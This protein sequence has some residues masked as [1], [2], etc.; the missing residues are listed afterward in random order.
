MSLK[1]VH[2]SI[3]NEYDDG[4]FFYGMERKISH[5]LIQ[6]GHFVYDFS[7]RDWERN[8]RFLGIKNSGLKKMNNKLIQ[9]CKNLKADILLLG[10]AEKIDRQTL[11]TIKQKLPNLKIAQWYVDHLKEN[12]NFFDNLHEVDTFF[13]ANALPL[14]ELSLKYKD[15]KFS[16]FPNISDGAFDRHL[17]MPK[18][19]DVIYIARDY[20]ED[21]RYKFATLLDEFCKN[22]GINHKIYASLGN[23]A[24]FGS[25]FHEAV[26]SAKIAINFN[27][28]DELES[29]NAKKL[30]GASDRM[31]QFMGCGV[32]TF[33]PRID[34]FEKLYEDKKE[35]V[36]FDSPDDCFD[37]IKE[38]LKYDKFK[39]I[40]KNGQEKTLKT[41]NAKRV[42][43]FMIEA[44]Q[45]ENFS[46]YY[47]WRE[48]IYKN[49]EQI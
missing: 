14:K 6:N 38:Y 18:T 3:F 24:V 30:L 10:K 19:T 39:D 49:G 45:N 21:V 25:E 15:A 47:E 35:I 20:K 22:N 4:N 9:I 40:A 36:Y 37:K 8:L 16:F 5:G 44:L 28:D 2:C 34:G 42:T 12:Q 23:K 31:A 32:C 26:N 1:I 41:A 33:S 13:Y 48:Y 7:Y 46:E 11:K 43:K 29:K 17:D 27:R